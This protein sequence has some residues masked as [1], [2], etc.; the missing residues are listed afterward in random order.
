MNV[1]VRLSKQNAF[2][3]ERAKEGDGDNNLFEFWLRKSLIQRPL[4]ARD[5]P[6]ICRDILQASCGSAERHLVGSA[7]RRRIVLYQGKEA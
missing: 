1:I 7:Y 6:P 5:D 2:Y 4:L 3:R